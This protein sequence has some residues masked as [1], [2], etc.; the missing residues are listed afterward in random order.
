MPPLSRRLVL[1]RAGAVLLPASVPSARLQRGILDAQQAR[2][3]LVAL[4]AATSLGA[5]AAVLD[6]WTPAIRRLHARHRAAA[7]TITVGVGT[8]LLRASSASMPAGLRPLPAFRGDALDPARSHGAVCLKVCADDPV[9]LERVLRTLL[10]R[11]HGALRARW[12]QDG[13]LDREAPNATPRNLLGFKDGSGNPAR[14]EARSLVSAAGAG[15]PGWMR[16]GTFLVVR[17]IV[18]DLQ[19]WSGLPVARQESI[20]G[21]HKQSGAPFGGVR[22][23]DHVNVA[24]LRSD[25]H[26]VRARSGYSGAGNP[27]P[28][29]R[30]GY[31]FRDADG[32]GLL[33]LA[34]TRD[35]HGAYVP[36]QQRL[37]TSDALAPF[38]EHRASAV[39]AIP[40]V[41]R[42][43]WTFT[44]A[45]Q[46]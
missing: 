3:A 2:I 28:L 23:H 27:A 25:A 12:R 4:D 15:V 18:T 33:F 36:I 10:A 35:P 9:V 22:E 43:G 24:L 39:F 16:G 40:P 32:S 38:V 5:V 13:F 29:L 17:R 8:S 20:I 37:A 1:A 44:R 31:S 14:A 26:V 41:S 19:A 7:L 42:P 30:R 6:G 11:S 21:R 46:P 34:F 45:L